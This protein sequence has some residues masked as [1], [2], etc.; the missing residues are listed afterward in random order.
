MATC[1]IC[2]NYGYTQIYEC[3][4][5]SRV[6][7]ICVAGDKRIETVKQALRDV[8]LDPESK[9]YSYRRYQNWKK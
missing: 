9:K 3:G 7:C 5:V 4:R 6:Y 8:G 1:S 2:S